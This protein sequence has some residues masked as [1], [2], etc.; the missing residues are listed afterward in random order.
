MHGPVKSCQRPALAN[1]PS[2]QPNSGIRMGARL[3]ACRNAIRAE[4]FEVSLLQRQLSGHIQRF[5]SYE[6]DAIG[7]GRKPRPEDLTRKTPPVRKG[8]L[9]WLL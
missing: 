3:S 2:D 8:D 7:S 6:A 1:W 9:R 4:Q 5:F